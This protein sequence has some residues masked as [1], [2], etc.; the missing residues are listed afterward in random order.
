M[1]FKILYK[2]IEEKDYQTCILTYDQYINFRRLPI[3]QECTIIKKDQQN[4][5]KYKEE[6]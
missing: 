3:V 6:M 2:F 5:E 1:Q 4:L